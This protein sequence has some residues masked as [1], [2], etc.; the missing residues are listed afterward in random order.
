MIKDDARG[1]WFDILTSLGVDASS[2]EKP[3]RKCPICP[4]SKDSFSY[5]DSEGIGTYYWQLW[6][7]RRDILRVPE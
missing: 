2:L 6:S 7:P 5:L 4:Q 1:H 3:N